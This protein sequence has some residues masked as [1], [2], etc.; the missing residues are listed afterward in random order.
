[1]QDVHENY[2][3][4]V[5]GTT[6]LSAAADDIDLWVVAEALDAIFDVFGDGDQAMIIAKEINLLQTLEQLAPMLRKRVHIIKL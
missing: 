6:L 3:I 1:M 2:Y 4:Q 5:I